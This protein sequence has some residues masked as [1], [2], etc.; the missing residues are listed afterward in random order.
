MRGLQTAESQTHERE[1]PKGGRFL[2]TRR[3]C[4]QPHTW[5]TLN[6]PRLRIWNEGARLKSVLYDKEALHAY[7]SCSLSFV[8]I[9]F[10]SLN[11]ADM[12]TLSYVMSTFTKSAGET[13]SHHLLLT[14]S[15]LSQFC[16]FKLSSQF[17]ACVVHLRMNTA[18]KLVF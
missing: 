6:V 7:I 11:H 18:R 15:L 17:T 8:D 14:C 5:K 10:L 13:S 4:E 16:I 3:A 1:S 9:F 12:L 2:K